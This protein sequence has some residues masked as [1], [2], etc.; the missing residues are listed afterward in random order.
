MQYTKLPEADV[1]R[2]TACWMA[3]RILADYIN[4][5]A[6]EYHLNH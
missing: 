1:G 5:G 4:Q 6:E 3:Y 2:I